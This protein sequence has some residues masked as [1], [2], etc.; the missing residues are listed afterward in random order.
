MAWRELLLQHFGPGQLGG[1]T[2]GDWLQL[3]RENHFAVAPVYLPRALAILLHSGQNSIFRWFE[4]SRLGRQLDGVYVEPPLFILG[5]WRQGTTH[6]HNLLTLDDRFAFPNNFQVLFPHTF[7]STEA[8]SAPLID[9]FLPRRRQIDNVEWN[10]RSPQEDEFALCVTTGMSPCMGW[11]F[12]RRWDHYQKYLTFRGVSECELARWKEAFLWFVKKLSF[13]YARPLILKSPPH[14]GRIQLILQLFP[15]ARFVHIHREPYVVFQSTRRMFDMQKPIRLQNSRPAE[16]DDRIV[17]QYTAMYD[18]FLSERALIAGERFHELSFEQLEAD[19]LGQM[20]RLYEA[21]R[22]PDFGHVEPAL[23]QYVHSV[24][25]Y[26]KNKFP[27][28]PAAMRQRI[29]QAW[30]SCFDEWGYPT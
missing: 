26:Q 15:Q 29:A 21:L 8:M 4:N 10:M 13:K 28:L 1:V 23:Q 22:L 11:I 16:L 20:G 7:L 6:L 30:R 24:A 2:L 17:R 25:G 27:E 14:T 5:H 3:L 9:F 19:P 12:P 18:A